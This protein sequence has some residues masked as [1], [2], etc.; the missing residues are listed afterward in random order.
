[1]DFP[2]YWK[3]E[4]RDINQG[5]WKMTL[6]SMFRGGDSL[7]MLNYKDKGGCCNSLKQKCTGIW[8]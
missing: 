4:G 3:S 5:F 7:M 6:I 8:C 2:E 1:M